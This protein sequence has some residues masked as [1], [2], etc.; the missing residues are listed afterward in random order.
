MH[1]ILAPAILALALAGPA[2]AETRN[3]RGFDTVSAADK[4][5]VFVTVGPYAVEV[6]GRDADRVRTEVHGDELRIRQANRSWFGGV[7]DINATVRV[8]MPEVEG[9]AAT[10]GAELT[11]SGIEGGDLDIAAAMGGSLRVSGTCDNLSAAASMGGS[12]EAEGLRCATADVAASMGGDAQVYASSTF[13][14]AASMGGSINVA[15]EANSGD[16]ATSMGGDVS[17]N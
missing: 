17:R 7:R 8:S 16:I 10:R 2:T 1:R 6:T 11:A 5:E 13:D 9:L 15:G 4:I 14:A 12:L 3:L